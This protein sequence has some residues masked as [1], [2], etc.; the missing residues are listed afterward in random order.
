MALAQLTFPAIDLLVLTFLAGFGVATSVFVPLLRREHRRGNRAAS[1]SRR[2]ARVVS[3]ALQSSTTTASTTTASPTTGSA[4]TSPSS[5]TAKTTPENQPR[6]V[7]EETDPESTLPEREDAAN[8]GD[9]DEADL[10]TA[11]SSTARR[12]ERIELCAA[13]HRVRFGQAKARLL[14][15]SNELELH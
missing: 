1:R 10:G 14:T 12:N 11:R 4:P 5:V 6:N 3:D 9:P 2:Q 8:P 15:I 13:K 7:A